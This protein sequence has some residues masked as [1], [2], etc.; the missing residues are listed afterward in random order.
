L[1]G[2]VV[3]AKELT[4][5]VVITNRLGPA[6]WPSLIGF[7]SYW[8][9]FNRWDGTGTPTL[10]RKDPFSFVEVMTISTAQGA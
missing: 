8:F 3:Q 6:G 7:F 1:L 5:K 2:K 10:G 4:L 9:K